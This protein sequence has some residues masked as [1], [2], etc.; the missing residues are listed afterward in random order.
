MIKK[1]NKFTYP[2]T[3]RETIDGK[4]HYVIGEYKLPSVTTI[5]SAT[6]SEEKRNHASRGGVGPPP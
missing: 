6:Q 5:L 4:R 2:G 1:I 3:N